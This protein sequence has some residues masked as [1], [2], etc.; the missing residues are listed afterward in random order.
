VKT[1]IRRPANHALHLVLTVLTLGMWAPVWIVCAVVGRR[2]T[3]TPPQH[4]P[5][6]GQPVW[7]PYTQ[8]WET[9]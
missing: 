9:R 3:V 2:E 1:V 6:P 4:Y 8:R 5:W 7:N